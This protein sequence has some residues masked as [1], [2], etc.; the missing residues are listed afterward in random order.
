[1]NQIIEEL[2]TQG[3]QSDNRFTEVFVHSRIERGYGPV[4]IVQ[5]LR[6]RSISDD[7]I[8]QFVNIHESKWEQ[9][10]CRVREKRFGQKLPSDFK[11]KA[12]QSRFLQYRGFTYEQLRFAFNEREV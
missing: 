10:A 6:R 1:V 11:D 3:L 9:R 7:L 2:R 12:K 8:N 4:R 5:E